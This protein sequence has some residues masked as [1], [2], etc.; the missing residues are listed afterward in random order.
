MTVVGW[1]MSNINTY[2]ISIDIIYLPEKQDETTKSCQ[3]VVKRCK[4]FMYKIMNNCFLEKKM[5]KVE[6][7][8]SHFRHFCVVILYRDTNK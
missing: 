8:M 2:F 4:Q 5:K 3:K 6:K 1:L 7:S